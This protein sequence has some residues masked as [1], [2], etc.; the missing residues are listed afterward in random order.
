MTTAPHY[1]DHSHEAD[2]TKKGQALDPF[3]KSWSHFLIQNL[4][5]Q[6]PAIRKKIHRKSFYEGVDLGKGSRALDP[7]VTKVDHSHKDGVAV[8]VRERGKGSRGCSFKVDPKIISQEP[9]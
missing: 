4:K 6:D 8:A 1:E 5:F 9:R 7:S 3:S 2:S